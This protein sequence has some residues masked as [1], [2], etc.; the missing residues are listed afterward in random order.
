MKKATKKRARSRPPRRVASRAKPDAGLRGLAPEL[1]VDL[2]LTM[3]RIRRAEETIAAL[4]PE[5]EIRCPTHLSIGQEAGAAGVCLALR[6]TDTAVSTHR[7]HAHY[8]AKGGDLRAMF[9]ELYGRA[10]GCCGGKGGSMHLTAPEV[11]MLGASAIVAGSVP[12]AVGTALAARMAGTD[13][14]AVAFFGDAAMEQG[15][16]HESLALAALR[17][18]PVLFVCENNLYAT[19]TP[20]RTRQAG[21]DMAPRAA[22]HWLPGATV[23]GNDVVAVYHAAKAAVERARRGRG[24]TLIE[25]KT[26]RFR[27]HVGPHYDID[28]GYRTQAELDRWMAREPVA[29]LARRLERAGVLTVERRQAL[30]AQVEAEVAD[31]VAFAKASPFPEPA[32]LYADVD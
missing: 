4:Y 23:D 21:T 31:A 27:E 19:N 28:L 12:L 2:Y 26:Y 32:A 1:L 30:D 14:V 20:L 5:Q 17:R 24:P 6:I 9:A 11:G 3:R 13:E 25:V 8:L 18:L 22:G 10:T 29:A 16:T 15:V 7:C